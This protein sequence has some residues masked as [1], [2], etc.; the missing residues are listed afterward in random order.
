MPRIARAVAPG[1]PHHVT[2]RGNFGQPV[3][4]DDEDRHR[5]LGWLARYADR[6]GTRIWAY[7]L[8]TNHIHLMGKPA[9][10]DSLAQAIG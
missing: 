2:Q 8:M 7:C 9:L 10:E 5:Y 3:F 6:H 4:D 1:L